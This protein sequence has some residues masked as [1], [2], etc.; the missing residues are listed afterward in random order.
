MCETG[1]HQMDTPVPVSLPRWTSRVAVCLFQGQLIVDGSD[2]GVPPLWFV[3]SSSR[4]NIRIIVQTC[5]RF[6]SCAERGKSEAY[7]GQVGIAV[8]KRLETPRLV[9]VASAG[10]SMRFAARLTWTEH[11]VQSAL[12]VGASVYISLSMIY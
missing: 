3:V 12:T 7:K 6:A 4:D 8:T 10:H 9:T 2:Q 1:P 5:E 11:E